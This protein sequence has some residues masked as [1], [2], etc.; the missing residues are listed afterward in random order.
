[1]LLIAGAHAA[2]T[3]DALAGIEGEIRIALVLLGGK[4]IGAL[5]AVAH[6]AQADDAR[7]ILQFAVAIGRT[8]QAVERMIGDVQLH[9]AAADVGESACS[10]W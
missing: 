6:F 4:V 7:H 5:I 2:R 3:D 8:G 9:H 1:M 10:A